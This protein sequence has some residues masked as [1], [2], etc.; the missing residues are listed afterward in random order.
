MKT[1]RAVTRLIRFLGALTYYATPLWVRAARGP[2]DWEHHQTVRQR[3]AR[4]AMK[5]L[6]ITIE[7][8]GQPYR[9]GACVYASN[10]RSWLDPFVDLAVVWAFPVAKAEVGK[11]PIVAQGARA[12]GILFVDRGDRSSRVAIMEEMAAALRRGHSLLVYPEGTTS[13]ETATREFKRGAFVAAEQ[14]GCPLVPMGIAYP[15]PH[16]HWGDGE[17]LWRNFVDVAGTRRTRVSLYIGAPRIVADAAGAMAATRTELDEWI[18][19]RRGH[20]AGV[21]SGVPV[22]ELREGESLEVGGRT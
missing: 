1:L 9:G 4:S 22:D 8:E 21:G 19:G 2:I 3:F 6:G 12:T 7:L 5:I 20:V 10:H 17:S 16:Y 18:L 13:T 14:S 11:L 15:S